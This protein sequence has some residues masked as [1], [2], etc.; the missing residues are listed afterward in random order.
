MRTW[1]GSPVE[2]LRFAAQSRL[3]VEFDYTDERGRFSRRRVEPYTLYQTK[4]ENIVLGVFDRR[5]SD[6]RSF[7]VD[8]I[9]RRSR[10]VSLKSEDLPES[11]PDTRE[12]GA[13]SLPGP[14]EILRPA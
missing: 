10:A 6:R 7:R 12:V 2:V 4:E 1:G 13:L 5:W 9:R 8:R 11:A 3:V 14:I